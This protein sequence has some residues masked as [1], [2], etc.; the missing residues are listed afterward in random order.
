[1]SKQDMTY[2]IKNKKLVH[3][4][5]VE[6]G[7]KC[8]CI[9]PGCGAVLIAR[10]GTKVKHHF[11]HKSTIEC[12]Y[13]YQTSIHLLAKEI[14]S[15]V[16][17]FVIPEL[18][19]SFPES[20]KRELIDESRTVKVQEVI[21]EKK[22]SD[23]IPDIL[24]ITDIGKIIVEIF[25]THEIDELKLEKLK[26]INIPTIEIDLSKIERNITEELLTNVLLEESNKKWIYHGKRGIVH[27]KFLSYAQVLETRKYKGGCY[28]DYCPLRIKVWDGI[29]YASVF[30]DC[31]ECDFC[32]DY[33]E[34][35]EYGYYKKIICSG[36]SKVTTMKDFE[37]T[38]E[39]R[40]AYYKEKAENDEM[41]LI[42][43]GICP[44]CGHNL[45]IR[46]GRYGEFFGC[47]Q[48]PK[49]KFTFGYKKMK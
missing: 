23:I 42:V 14:I 22:V 28:V 48:Y 33:C 15:K 11:A 31:E 29:P 18:Y 35:D 40:A 17:E 41:D 9:C 6:S 32:F 45:I 19:F 44:R 8:N 27:G 21:L 7:L 4:S 47:S 30:H 20:G 10:K 26:K 38:Y 34:P 37:L 13:G 25:V 36:K 39:E 12:E 16:H 1:M 43:N 2:A 3:I 5:E 49:C 46:N 24:L